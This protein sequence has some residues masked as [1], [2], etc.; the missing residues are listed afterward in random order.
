MSTLTTLI[1]GPDSPIRP[2][3][4]DDLLR[5]SKSLVLAEFHH[6]VNDGH[7]PEWSFDSSILRKLT[8][9]A[10]KPCLLR[11]PVSHFSFQCRLCSASPLPLNLA[12]E[13]DLSHLGL[14]GMTTKHIT[15]CCLELRKFGMIIW[16]GRG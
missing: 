10:P 7:P 12:H 5:R 9:C 14:S 2:F 1:L 6:L 13:T 15:A 4:L 8:V 3:T 11:N 16:Y